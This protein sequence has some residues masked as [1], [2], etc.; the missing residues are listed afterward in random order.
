MESHRRGTEK[1][2][3][4]RSCW[5]CGLCPFN[6]DLPTSLSNSLDLRASAHCLEMRMALVHSI[7]CASSCTPAPATKHILLSSCY[8]WVLGAEVSNL[9]EITLAW[10]CVM[11]GC[12]FLKQ[13]ISK[14]LFEKATSEPYHRSQ[15]ALAIWNQFLGRQRKYA[16]RCQLSLWL[17][18]RKEPGIWRSPICHTHLTETLTISQHRSLFSVSFGNPVNSQAMVDACAEHFCAP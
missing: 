18:Q 16:R 10:G 9:K 15:E 13:V 17:N 8:G 1:D 2:G 5:L 7:F 14:A 3:S 12:Y 4:W 11:W 6:H